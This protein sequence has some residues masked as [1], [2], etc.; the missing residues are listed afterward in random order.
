MINKCVE[1]LAT[2]GFKPEMEGL[3]DGITWLV[4]SISTVGAMFMLRI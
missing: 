3:E 2:S 4:G 1:R